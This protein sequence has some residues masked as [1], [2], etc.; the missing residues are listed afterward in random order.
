MNQSYSFIHVSLL[1]GVPVSF[2]ILP[3]KTNLPEWM[4]LSEVISNRVISTVASLHGVEAFTDDLFLLPLAKVVFA[5]YALADPRLQQQN[6]LSQ[7]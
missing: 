3:K 1:P 5:Y 6:R 2:D 7:I 4:K